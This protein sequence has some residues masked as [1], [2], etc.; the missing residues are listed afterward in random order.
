MVERKKAADAGS[1]RRHAVLHKIKSTRLRAILDTE[2]SFILHRSGTGDMHDSGNASDRPFR[3]CAVSWPFCRRLISSTTG[4]GW[5]HDPG[6]APAWA[7]TPRAAC[8]PK[9]DRNNLW[10]RTTI[11]GSQTNF[12]HFCFQVSIFLSYDMDGSSSY[13]NSFYSE[14]TAYFKSLRRKGTT[15]TNFEDEFF[16][17]VRP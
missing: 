7:E 3:V 5:D 11:V 15:D 16:Y 17:T 10:Y 2:F 6:P 4:A 1:V 9:F 12:F 8:A 14:C 13:K